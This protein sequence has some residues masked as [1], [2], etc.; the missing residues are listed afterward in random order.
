VAK[1]PS[2]DTRALEPAKGD[3]S[4]TDFASSERMKRRVFLGASIILAA[5]RGKTGPTSASAPTA[6]QIALAPAAISAAQM[7]MRPLG[8]TGVLVSRIGLGG[9]HIGRQSDEQESI[10]IIR[11]AID[12]GVTFMDNAWDYNG[13]K[14]EE[15]MGKALRDGY[16]QKAFLM[17]KLDGRTKAAATEQLEQSLRRLQT[18]MID[19]VQVH[20]VIRFSDP[21]RVFGMGGAIEAL[22]DARKAG[23]LRFI[24]FTGHKSPEIHLAMLQAADDHGFA[25]DTIQMPLNVMDAHFSSFEQKVLPVAVHKGMGILHMKPLGG[26]FILE[27]NVVSAVECLQ[28]AMN[29]PTSVMI[30]GCDSMGILDQAIHAAID[31]KPLSNAEVESLLARTRATAESGEFERFK[32]SDY[33]DSTAKHPHWL[34]DAK[35]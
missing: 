26:G 11:R 12:R 1:R 33:F 7:P 16:R 4:G 22:T 6:G 27:S 5:C 18:E 14:S 21:A 34:E 17:T 35:I 31:F 32:T 19:L 23:K 13:G 29:L 30:T 24:G 8:K 3:D 15:R 10:R 20:E 25:F 28:Y 9:A 2:E